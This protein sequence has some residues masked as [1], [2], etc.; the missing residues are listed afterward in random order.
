L[1]ILESIARSGKPLLIIAEDMEGEALATIILNK[2]RG[3]LNV[4]AVKAPGFGD[5][6]KAMLQDI[7]IMTGGKVISEELGMKLEQTKLED[8][9]RAKKVTVDKENTLIVEGFGDKK[10]INARI[11][12]IKKEI[13]ESTSDYDKE[14][15][16]ERLAKLAGGVAV[17]NVGAATE[18]EMKEK[19][20]RVEDALSATRAAVEEGIVPG[21]GVT[22]IR[23]A[24]KLAELENQLE[25]DQKIGVMIVRKALEAPIKRIA[26]NAGLDG[27]IV[28]D[29]ARKEKTNIGY[30]AQKNEWVDMWERG[31]IDPVKVERVALENAA[32]V[33]A[34]FITTECA[35]ADKPEEEKA[36]GMPH[37]GHGMPD[38]Y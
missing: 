27:S 23:V 28:A 20:A 22:A 11:A 34:L 18:I 15:L 16:Q 5:R 38:M 2:L 37:G 33:A 21:G 35:V 30:D 9:G 32:S 13:E 31:I 24:D 36:K 17:I 14:K 10:A 7:A 3:T 1:P 29:R 4:V 25:G 8:L 6:R 12:Q 26:E 19:K